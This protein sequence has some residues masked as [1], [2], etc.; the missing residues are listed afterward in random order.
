MTMSFIESMRPVSANRATS[1]GDTFFERGRVKEFGAGDVIFSQ[2]SPCCTLYQVRSGLL[3]L[4]RY[5]A[6]GRSVIVRMARPGDVIG[7]SEAFFNQEHRWEGG[8]LTNGW[9]CVLPVS[10]WLDTKE[11][12]SQ[13][14]RLLG[15]AYQESLQLE[16]AMSRH[17]ALGAEDRL[18]SFLLSL[19]SEPESYP[20]VVRIPLRRMYVSEIVAITRESCS[21][22]LARMEKAGAIKWRDRNTLLIAE[23]EARRLAPL[24]EQ[25]WTLPEGYAASLIRRQ[26]RH[27]ATA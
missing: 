15:L 9:L 12:A 16:N 27:S 6:D 24:V 23:S 20:V 4:R 25:F 18:M 11:H 21:R 17:A 26:T 8:A 5:M 13:R 7:W 22:I 3:G 19:A 10:V 14:D 1:Q 2:G